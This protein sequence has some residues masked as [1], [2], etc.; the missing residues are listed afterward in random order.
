MY[1][2]GMAAK[3]IATATFSKMTKVFSKNRIPQ[4]PR[5]NIGKGDTRSL[6]AENQS[7]D[8]L[9]ESGYM[10][11]QLKEKHP[12]KNAGQKNPDLEVFSGKDGWQTHDV[13]APTTDKVGTVAR[14]LEE[15]IAKNQ[16]NRFVV[17]LDDS[18][19]SM[20]DFD[21]ASYPIDGLEDLIFLKKGKVLNARGPKVGPLHGVAVAVGLNGGNRK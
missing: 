18:P 9:R 16:A 7:A 11:K 17:R 6:K 20:D 2:I 21:F 15:K 13:Y 8:E 5:K 14:T 4:G 3:K 19:L 10:V 1:P 12:V